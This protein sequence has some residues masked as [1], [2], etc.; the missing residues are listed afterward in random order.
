ME[1]KEKDLAAG[2]PVGKG[3]APKKKKIRKARA[4]QLLI[5]GPEVKVNGKTVAGGIQTVML[6]HDPPDMT[7]LP[8]FCRQLHSNVLNGVFRDSLSERY[9]EAMVPSVRE[10]FPEGVKT[11][12]KEGNRT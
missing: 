11:K 7:G 6:V 9:P 8:S 12:K 1:N 5:A 10:F 4:K 2:K 3:S